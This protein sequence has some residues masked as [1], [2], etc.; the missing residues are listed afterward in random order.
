ME[1]SDLFG[2]LIREIY[3]E[4]QNSIFTKEMPEP[5]ARTATAKV[6]SITGFANTSLQ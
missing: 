2:R 4:I 3:N 5:G 6:W 1:A